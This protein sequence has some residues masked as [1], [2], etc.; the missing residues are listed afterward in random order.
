MMKWE[1]IKRNGLSTILGLPAKVW[2]VEHRKNGTSRYK[3]RKDM[4]DADLKNLCEAI[5][6]NKD[7]ILTIG[8][9]YVDTIPYNRMV[10]I[11]N[12]L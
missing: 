11:I 8:K 9:T 2:S 4:S 7:E 3:F 12:K 10:D 5:D 6:N 1:I